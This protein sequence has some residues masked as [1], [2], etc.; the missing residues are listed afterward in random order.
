MHAFTGLDTS[1][2]AKDTRQYYVWDHDGDEDTED[3]LMESLFKAAENGADDD[4]DRGTF[5]K[6]GEKVVTLRP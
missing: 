5:W 4:G 1:A 2:S 6:R 3:T